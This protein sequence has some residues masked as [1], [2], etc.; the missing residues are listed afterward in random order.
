MSICKT[1]RSS[2]RKNTGRNDKE[3]CRKY[4][5][6]LKFNPKSYL[7]KRYDSIVGRVKRF[8]TYKGRAVSFTKQ[9]F[10]NFGL[11]DPSFNKLYNE[12]KESGFSY[13]LTPSVDRIDNDKGYDLTNI[14]FITLVDNIKKGTK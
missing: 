11:D 7:R 2:R 13:S 8:K 10:V 5:A 9:E 4:R 1:C 3:Y 12:W 6:N 14:Q